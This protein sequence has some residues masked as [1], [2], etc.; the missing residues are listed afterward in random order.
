MGLFAD[1]LEANREREYSG[2]IDP[3]A[4][5]WSFQGSQHSFKKYRDKLNQYEPERLSDSQVMQM[6]EEFQGKIFRTR[7]IKSKLFN[8]KKK[9]F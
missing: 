7:K 6:K 3:C 1:I 8:C 5:M 2:Y 9:V 4:I